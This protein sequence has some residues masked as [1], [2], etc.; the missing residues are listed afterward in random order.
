MEIIIKTFHGLEEVL[1]EEVT[2]IINRPC[3]VRKRAVFADQITQLEL[4]TL[5]K[6]LRT[7]L[8]ILVQHATFTVHSYEDIYAALRTI[9]WEDLF[10]HH[11]TISI[12]STVFS[13]YFKNSQYVMH[14]SKDAVVDHF[15]DLYDKRPSVERKNADIR[16][17][18][19]ITERNMTVSLDSSGESLH[20]RGY[21][22]VEVKAPI[23]EVLAAGL[24]KLSNWDQTKPFWD[25]M[26]GSGTIPI[27]AA[28]LK[29]NITSQFN[30]DDFCFRHWKS[31]DNKSWQDL[32]REKFSPETAPSPIY[33]SDID[34]DV[35]FDLEKQVRSSKLQS[36]ISVQKQN[37]FQIEPLKEE[38]LMI[39]NPPYNKRLGLEDAKGFYKMI[40]DTLK[41]K[42]TGSS[43][44]VFSGDKEAIKFV[45][46][47][48]SKKII[49]YN[50]PIEARFHKFEMF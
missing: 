17:N 14:K 41:Q 13:K 16:I 29:Y 23:N 27:E 11:N 31:F 46:L 26:C 4:Y 45:G 22:Q 1:A 8:R 25:P 33:G 28:L 35:I 9:K 43:A 44:W 12:D 2:S 47:R 15:R 38:R 37:F 24:I 49:L 30:R 32:N 3:Q 21:K 34:T 50:G 18:I 6:R 39:F 48:P 10:Y 36:Y 7:A 40:G 19:H 20:K 42:C 5:N